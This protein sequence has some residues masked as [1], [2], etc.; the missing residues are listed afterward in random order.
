MNKRKRKAD[1]HVHS[2]YS[3]RPAQWILR[4]L[5][6][7]ESY[8]EPLA[9]YGLAKS[10]GMDLVTIT[11]HNTLAGALEIAHLEGTFL[12]E[13]ITTYFP[14]DRCK[15]HVLA[16]R[17][18]EAQHEDISRLRENVFELAAYLRQQRI[19]H[20]LAHPMY[21]VNDRLTFE[22]FEMTLLLFRNFELNGSRDAEQNDILAGILGNLTREE[23][24]RLAAKHRLA[25]A[26]AE[27]WRKNLVGGSD[28]HASLNVAGTH[29]E[30]DEAAGVDDFLQAVEEG[31]ARV[32]GGASSPKH[33]AHTIYSVTYQFYK[34]R[35]SL[36]R[37]MDADP[38]LSFADRLLV[39]TGQTDRGKQGHENG[40][41]PDTKRP[42]VRS[43]GASWSMQFLLEKEA[44]NILRND[45]ELLGIDGTGGGGSREAT[46]VW[47]RFVDRIS[48]K[49]L[50][51]SADNILESVSGANLFDIFHA[52]GS[53]GSLYTLL[54]PYFVGYT[55][56]TKDRLHASAW[57]ER[58]GAKPRSPELRRLKI[59]HFT[60][61]F[62]D[63]NGV[64]KTLQMQLEIARK[65]H[66]QLEMI[67]CGPEAEGF[68][69]TNFEP[70]G[71][72]EMPEYSLMKLYYPPLLKML[73]YCYEG[74]FTHIHAATPGPIG[75]A[76]LAIARILHLPLYGTY[77]TALPQYITQL[78]DDS[79]LEDLVWRYMI[80]FYGQADV[81]YV[82]SRA[83]GEELVE[84]GIP[85][86]KIKFY[87]RGI[88]IDRFHPSKA[89]GFFRRRFHLTEKEIKLLYV[90]RV[91][92]EKN[93][94]ELVEVFR[95]A[96]AVRKGIR[97]VVVGEGPYL[98][99]MRKALQ[100]LPVTFTG[101][102]T[103]EDL[104]QAYASSDIFVFP[105]TT[106]TFGNVVLEAQA[107]GIPVVVTD[108][109]GPQENLVPGRT[110]YVAS[111]ADPGAFL[112][113]VLQLIDNPQ[114][115][116][117]MK[118]NARKYV[119]DRSFEAAY[120][121]LWESYRNCDPLRRGRP[122]ELPSLG[123]C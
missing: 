44:R 101:F 61:T 93:L 21:S 113:C 5:G 121:R 103:G 27:P 81:V 82:P 50:R 114:L 71:T 122:T 107:S 88:D 100:G 105:S 63:V 42:N 85:E 58:L 25:P 84:K 111:S 123:A 99:D 96:A 78:T 36:G 41:A 1:L 94:P 109:G 17:I 86:E 55:H 53:V 60:D 77:H 26:F 52:I 56:F 87:P 97:L 118:R 120:L 23:I 32:C 33:L 28:D 6:A 38:V 10:R 20:A 39:P 3:K 95:K 104:S 7:S 80:W 2:K 64:A 102:L 65:N 30:V 83:T 116:N 16:Y 69:I 8:T 24:E 43:R 49:V 106:D 92:R 54:V 51:R 68:G 90:G 29:T 115:L 40:G 19:V 70:I 119:R 73:D 13:E 110:G 48:E 59:A 34:S 18:T 108:R 75:L 98:E 31:R 11:D 4:K 74:R 117:K 89:N 57:S 15:L 22:H 37:L 66:K 79:S 45:T 72:F 12:S 9:V 112:K 46:E 67:T 91:S 76:A 62:Y 14:E 35:F 47:F